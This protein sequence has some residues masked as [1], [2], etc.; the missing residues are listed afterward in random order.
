MNLPTP[1]TSP[2]YLGR[3][4][5]EVREALVALQR[6]IPGPVQARPSAAV[7]DHPFRV[8]PEG[9]E[10]V[11]LRGGQIR[12]HDIPAVNDED[13][14]IKLPIYGRG[15]TVPDIT[16]IEVTGE[17][18]IL[19][20]VPVI[21]RQIAEYYPGDMTIS[22]VASWTF[23]PHGSTAPSAIFA[24]ADPADS[25]TTGAGNIYYDVADVD[26]A[27]GVAF[28]VSQNLRENVTLSIQRA[29]WGS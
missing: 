13:S 3:F 10:H 16:E 19:L 24:T 14:D 26:I 28:V 8:V 23:I 25:A 11:T 21:S 18:K 12:W 2:A 7:P 20:V 29:Y 17:G 15:L 27:D 4:T 5:R 22:R 6:R 9:D 1:I